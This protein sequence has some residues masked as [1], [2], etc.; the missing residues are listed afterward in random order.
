[1]FSA[2][3]MMRLDALILE[4]DERGVLRELG[5]LCAMHIVPTKAGPETAPLEPCDRGPERSRCN[6]L[7]ERIA[8]LR[9]RLELPAVGPHGP[10]SAEGAESSLDEL[11]AAMTGLEERAKALAARRDSLQR[12]W[13]Q[14]AGL[15]EQMSG[16]GGVD[17]PFDQISR[18]SFHHFALGRL[19][20][21]RLEELRDKVGSNVVLLPLPG[22][23]GAPPT[24]V[25]V[26]SRK[27]RFA[28]HTAL[29]QTGFERETL[30]LPVGRTPA[31]IAQ[32][33]AREQ[34][35]LEEELKQARSDLAAL[36]QT[37]AAGLGHM[38]GILKNECRIL[39]AE[40][41][42]PRTAA[43]VLMSGWVPVSGLPT[44][45]VRLKA[46]TGGRC[47]IETTSPDDVPDDQIPVLLRQ[48]RFLRPF[49]MLTTGYGLPSYREL[50]PTLFV[51]VTYVLMFG[52]MFGDVGHGAI[53][54]LGGGAARLL[55]RSRK[56]RDLG[57]LVLLAGF[58]SIAFGFVYGSCFGLEFFR[59]LALWQDPLE[60][61]T[62]HLMLVGVAVGVVIISTGLVLNIINRFRRRDY[63]GG[64]LDKFGVTGVLFYWGVLALILKY[65]ALRERGLVS[66]AVMLAIALPLAIWVLKEPI[67]CFLSH[68]PGPGA[69][70]RRSL[71]EAS[72][73][74]LVEAF[75]AVLVYM[76]NTISFVRL[77]A[78][79]MS[80]AAILMATFVVAEEVHNLPGGAVWSVVVI[81]LGNAVA[82]L[83]EGI[84]ASVQAL[85]LEYYEF[86]SKF[87]SGSGQAFKPFR[88]GGGPEGVGRM[89]ESK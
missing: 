2:E 3:R 14:V 48:P 12:Q 6:Q 36:A 47:V 70:P 68:R 5:E 51:A 60:G 22:G 87:Y 11:D 84:I 82:L 19:P 79:A 20:E 43:T 28:L 73:E 67:A 80:H 9:R 76:A 77:A 24:L 37:A 83:L 41:Q 88:L 40:E 53:L 66:L 63:A 42:F 32:E 1:M 18:A 57:V 85:R 16:Y 38:E 55:G 69:A 86:F 13:G 15:V 31:V 46:I 27:G 71:F 33:G 30:A 59:H 44:V 26:T 54:A 25:A 89:A 49:G 39:E 61:N 50:E 21:G 23:K 62:M 56:V 10:L 78:Y 52:M 72:A 29:E 45:E 75:E 7:L 4:R 35:R 81:V 34:A 74:S 17:I 64:L 8:G 65:A 58:S